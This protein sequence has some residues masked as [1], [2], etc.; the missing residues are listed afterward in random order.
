MLH[1]ADRMGFLVLDEIFD[2]W[3]SHKVKND[4]QTIFADW[5]EP[6]VRA[7]IR[8]DRNHPSIWA[9]SFG[10]E[11]AEQGSSNGAATAQRLRDMIKEEDSTRKS[12]VGMNNAGPNTAFTSIVD[13]IGL[14]YQGEGK[15][16][17]GPTFENFRSK[18]ADKMIFS[19]ESSSVVSSRGTYFFPVVSGNN[20]IVGANGPGGDSKTRQVSSYELY[21][22]SWGASPDKVFEAQDRYPYVA[23]EFVWTGWDYLGEPTPY[24]SSS[25]SSYFGIIDL[26]GFPKDRFYL[27]QARWNPNV[28]M[29]HILPHWNWPDRVGQETPV[30]V[31]SS[32]DEAE[33]FVNGVSQGKQKKAQYTYRFRWDKVTYQ[34][35]EVRVVAYKDGKEWA[36]A[37]IRTTGEATSLRM[38]TYNDRTSIRADGS[39]LSFVSV[40]VV[41]GKGDVVPTAEPMVSFSITG[42]GEIVSTDNGDATDMTAFPSKERKAFRGR[43]LAIVKAKSGASEPLTVT[44]TAKG[45]EQGKIILKV[46]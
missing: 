31:F 22:V 34:P 18:F 35:G 14:N 5:S 21:A 28:R 20:A 12:T 17:G 32:G 41:D 15:G 37:T 44:A 13:L 1:L 3:G 45:L 25:R 2:T 9:W 26:A 10:N 29:A 38:E 33:L 8:R 46:E 24:D 36:N 4:F 23:G 30:H 27:Y 7:F 40:A 43:A 6:D 11:V 39:D 19:T 16:N 42:P